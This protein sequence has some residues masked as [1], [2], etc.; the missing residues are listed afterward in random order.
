MPDYRR[1]RV[2]GGTCFFTVN[3][4]GRGRPLLVEHIDDLRRS[5]G[6]VRALMPFHIDARVVLPEHMHAL[7]TLPEGDADFP[8]RWQAIKMAR[9]RV[10]NARA[11]WEPG[12]GHDD[13]RGGLP[14]ASAR[15]LIRAS[16]PQV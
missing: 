16:S 12:V 7:W 11:R 6:R 9:I 3:L 5:V 4:P 15:R 14:A 13:A 1:N 2:P 8:R 10:P